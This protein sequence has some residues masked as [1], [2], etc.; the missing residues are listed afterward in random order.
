MTAGPPSLLSVAIDIPANPAI[1]WRIVA[2]VERWPEW[3]PTI[4]RVQRLDEGPLRL[5]SR[6]RI[7]QPRLPVAMWEVTD[8][9]QESGFTWVSSSP[10]VRVTAGHWIEPHAGGSRVSL[11]VSFSGLLGSLVA[12]LTRRLNVTYLHQEAEGL[13]KRAAAAGIG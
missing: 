12:R 11:S 8:L 5:G 6:A 10:L 9:E 1:V 4:T 3:T 13:R 2:E 7:W